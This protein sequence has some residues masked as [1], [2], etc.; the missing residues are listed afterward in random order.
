M[1]VSI[2]PLKENLAAAT[3]CAKTSRTVHFTIN[4][5]SKFLGPVQIDVCFKNSTRGTHELA[6][7]PLG[8]WKNTLYIHLY[9]YSPWK[10]NRKFYFLIT[11]SFNF[12][13]SILTNTAWLICLTVQKLDRELPKEISCFW[14]SGPIDQNDADIK[15]HQTDLGIASHRADHQNH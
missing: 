8:R 14:E 5:S 4:L 11:T 15:I 10:R 9:I 12:F 7:T 1:C 6:Q 3:I 13:I 2:G